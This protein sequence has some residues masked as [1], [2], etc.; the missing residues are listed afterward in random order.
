[1]D[2]R[3]GTSGRSQLRRKAATQI[4][5]PTRNTVWTVWATA[6]ATPVCTAGGSLARRAGLS[7]WLAAPAGIR[8]PCRSCARLPVSRLAKMAPNT[9]VP[10]EPPIIR[11]KVLAEVAVPSSS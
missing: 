1:M 3:S 5:T 4:G 9:A 8:T 7:I 6:W 10:N 2:R 11:K